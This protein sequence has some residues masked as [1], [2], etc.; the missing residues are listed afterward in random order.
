MPAQS[1]PLTPS[2]LLNALL[3]L[4]PRL[5]YGNV[6]GFL[7]GRSFYFCF[8]YFSFFWRDSFV[9]EPTYTLPQSFKVSH[10]FWAFCEGKI[11]CACRAC[12]VLGDSAK[13][14]ACRDLAPTSQGH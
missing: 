2:L 12:G 9:E 3:A 10:P 4:N 13:S 6:G 1:G 7:L 8:K 11:C 14:L 5:P